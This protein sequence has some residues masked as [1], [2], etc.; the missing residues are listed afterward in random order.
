MR[1]NF[2]FRAKNA[3][4][5]DCVAERSQFELSGDFVIEDFGS[6]SAQSFH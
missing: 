4:I 6:L 1:I 3:K 2:E 5:P